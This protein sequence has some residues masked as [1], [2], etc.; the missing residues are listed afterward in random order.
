MRYRHRQSRVVVIFVALSVTTLLGIDLA[1]ALDVAPATTP[2]N[3]PAAALQPQTLP[4]ICASRPAN[5][6]R[7]PHELADHYDLAELHRNGFD[8]R[9]RT[10]A[11]IEFNQ[12]VNHQAFTDWRECF[13]LPGDPLDQRLISINGSGQAVVTQGAL[14][15]HGNE[16]Q[17]DFQA[18]SI[19]APNI[20]RVYALVST[21]NEKT[22]LAAIL[23]G[24]TDASLT[25]GHRVDVVS[26]SFGSCETEWA[27][28]PGAIDRTER[29]LERMAAAGIWFFKAAGD[30]GPSECPHH[31]IC[32]TGSQRDEMMNYP[33]S[34]PSVLSVG[35]TQFTPLNT[36][37]VWNA[38]TLTTHCSAGGGG[39]SDHFST[40]PAWQSDLLTTKRAGRRVPDVSALAGAPGY[41]FL[42][43]AGA[44]QSGGG[45]SFAAPLYAG[46]FASLR[47]ALSSKGVAFPSDLHELL[48]ATAKGNEVD[49]AAYFDVVV[50][51]NRIYPEVDCCDAA[52]GFDI[53]SGL[54]ELRFN[55]LLTSMTTPHDPIAPSF[56]G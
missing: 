19:G 8:G 22:D 25:D 49:R 29:A 52:D 50:G 1:S 31:P 28:T 53:A 13:G 6:A 4:A 14:P 20:D 17:G 26:L 18:I 11:I 10:A 24:I 30:A 23:D 54:G 39:I 12:S 40:T 33:A 9:G 7:T 45:T 38:T 48:Y 34:S 37:K 36:I 32:G 56:T 5:D 21:G 35:G 47:T 43:G 46:A 2:T 51:N 41:A 44:W 3:A 42:T 55:K 27:S 16:A 15:A